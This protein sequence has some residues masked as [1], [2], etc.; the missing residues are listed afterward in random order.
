MLVILGLLLDQGTPGLGPGPKVTWAWAFRAWDPGRKARKARGPWNVRGARE[1]RGPG[2]RGGGGS[3]AW[4][5]G[6]V[7]CFFFFFGAEAFAVMAP[8]WFGCR[9]SSARIRSWV[10]VL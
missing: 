2:P 1:A 6:P 3:K 4:D 7:A 5:F 8:G 10:W 9:P